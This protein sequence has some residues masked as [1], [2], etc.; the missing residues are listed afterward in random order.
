MNGAVL[1]ALRERTDLVQNRKSIENTHYSEKYFKNATLPSLNARL[2]Y[3]ATGLAGRQLIRGGDGFPPPVIGEINKSVGDLL[4]DIFSGQFP[5]WTFS[6]NM[7]YPIG[8]SS[9]EASLASTRLQEKQQDISLR[10]AEL[11]VVTEVRN[12]ARQLDANGKRV[13]ATRSARILAERRLEAEEKKFAAGMSTSFLVIQAQR[14]LA[15]A[16][17]NEL[18]AILDYVNSK[19]DYETVQVA[20]VSG[21]S[22]FNNAASPTTGTGQNATTGSNLTTGAST[23]GGQ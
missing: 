6:I 8:T 7:S 2:D 11:G 20:P 1:R 17:I 21:A 22:N 19:T 23:G 16:K 3:N 13:D 5:Q 10:N 18:R 9:A 12:A 14:D 4:S 15:Q